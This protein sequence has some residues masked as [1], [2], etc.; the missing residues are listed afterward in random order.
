MRKKPLIP[1]FPSE[2]SKL[3]VGVGRGWVRRDQSRGAA[4]IGENQNYFL[5][6]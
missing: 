2:D 3:L 1:V 5:K 6:H 4:Q